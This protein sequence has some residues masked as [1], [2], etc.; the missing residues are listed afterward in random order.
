MANVRISELTELFTSDLSSDDIIPIVDIDANATKKV[1]VNSLFS[2]ATANDYATFETLSA[3]IDN[4]ESR[5]SSNT[6]YSIDGSDVNVSANLIPTGIYNIGSDAN[7]W[8]AGY[9]NTSIN[10]GSIQ[11]SQQDNSIVFTDAFNSSVIL[12]TSINNIS[13]SIDQVSSN[14]DSLSA[15]VSDLDDRV[16][17]NIFFQS[18]TH[19]VIVAANVVSNAASSLGS[20]TERWSNTYTDTINLGSFEIQQTQTANV[21]VVSTVIYSRHKNSFNSV[22]LLVNVEDL[23]YNQ[24]QSSELLLVHD[25]STVRITEYAIVHTSTNPIAT[26]EAAF[27]GD[28]V[29]L[30]VSAQSSDNN[31]TVLQFTN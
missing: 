22:K 7:P 2:V 8:Q 23:T 6:F 15:N 29:Q 17:S 19:S 4:V 14:V 21:N 20:T 10:V 5:R 26:F 18:N 9:F 12:N 16:Q 30:S 28:D 27:E 25:R 24:F 1:T 11:L 13:L 3:A 31:I